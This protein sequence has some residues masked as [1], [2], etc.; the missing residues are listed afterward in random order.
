MLAS[1]G[2]KLW[3]TFSW[4]SYT[5]SVQVLFLLVFEDCED[6]M[7]YCLTSGHKLMMMKKKY[8]ARKS[9]HNLTLSPFSHR[10]APIVQQ[11]IKEYEYG[12][13]NCV[14][15]MVDLLPFKPRRA[16][17]WQKDHTTVYENALPSP[18]SLKHLAKLSGLFMIN[19]VGPLSVKQKHNHRG[20]KYRQNNVFF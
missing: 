4:K 13:V 17:R 1:Q 6:L 10:A 9:L 8:D 7:I 2:A 20:I 3:H 12:C 15:M 5:V 14:K 11:V 18:V 16:C 19:D